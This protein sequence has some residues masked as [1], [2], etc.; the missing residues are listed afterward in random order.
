LAVLDGNVARVLSRLFALSAA[1]RDPQGARRLWALAER[2]VP[3]RGAGEWNQALMELGA[4]VCLPR[5]PRCGACPVFAHCR[6]YATN[7]VHAFPPVVARRT[8]VAMRRAVALIARGRRL[9]MARREGPLLAGLWEPPGVGLR[10]GASARAPV[11][12]GLARLGVRA[13]LSPIRRSVRH[14]MTHRAITVSLWRGEPAAPPPRSARLRWVD[15]GRPSVPL[16]ALARRVGG[17][18][19]G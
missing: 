13:C 9:L 3:E 7:R 15:L 14:D 12:A 8:P 19:I 4:T 6:A 5:A 11:E 16:T 1:V 17:E 2:L 10:A 18:R